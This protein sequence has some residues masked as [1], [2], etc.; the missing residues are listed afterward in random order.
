MSESDVSECVIC[1]DEMDDYNT[2]R[3]LECNHKLH[4][5][6]F[7]EYE[8]KT[9]THKELLT[10]PIC[11]H[12]IQCTQNVIYTSSSY[13]KKLYTLCGFIMCIAV[14]TSISYSMLCYY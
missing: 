7:S 6:C 3:T 12:P 9:S 2:I 4:Y 1:L 11:N 8:D 5:A 10:C 13:H 14:T